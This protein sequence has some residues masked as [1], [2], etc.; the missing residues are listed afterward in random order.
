MFLVG[1]ILCNRLTVF[2]ALCFRATQS[3]SDKWFTLEIAPD[4]E[5][6]LTT[7]R[8]GIHVYVIH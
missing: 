8:K 1:C 4:F 5:R 7:I 6:L 2:L 3:Y